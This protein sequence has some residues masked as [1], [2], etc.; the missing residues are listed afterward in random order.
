ML[1]PSRVAASELGVHPNT[2]RNWA[3]EG[4]IKFVKTATGQRRYDLSTLVR[5]GT[6]NEKKGSSICYCR[7]SSTKQRDDIERQ[8]AK[9]HELYPSYEIVTDIG[10]GLNFKRKGFISILERAMRGDVQELVVAHRD[11]LCRFGFDLVEWII[12]KNGGRVMVLDNLE[13]SPYTELTQDLLSILQ[14]FSRRLHSL[15]KYGTKI[16]NDPDLSDKIPEDA[17]EADFGN[18]SLDVQ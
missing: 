15:R 5:D 7:V 1:V 6:E 13:V 17:A 18:I 10:S 3:N 8:A 16:K 12:E 9:M 2:L 14:V 4:R 11:R